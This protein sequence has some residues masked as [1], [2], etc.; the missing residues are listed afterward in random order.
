[1]SN[2][3]MRILF[4]WFE[5]SEEQWHR[6]RRE[7]LAALDPLLMCSQTRMGLVQVWA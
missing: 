7:L 1:M 6:T 5:K 4:V 2:M 3:T